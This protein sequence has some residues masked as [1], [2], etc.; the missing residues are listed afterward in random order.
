[1]TAPAPAPRWR[2]PTEKNGH[3]HVV[4][5]FV[6][7]MLSM[8]LAALNQTVLSTALPTI[9]GELNGVNEMLWVITAFILTS[10]I[11]MPVYGKLG[12]LMGRKSL[13][14]GAIVVFMAGSVLGA[15][16]DSMAVL[17]AARAVQGVGGGGL[18]ILS[19]A[20]I[21]DVVPARERGKYMG[22]MGGVFAIAS[23]AGPLLGGWFT[24]GPGWRWVFWINIPLGLLALAAAAVFLKLPRHPGRPRLDLG[25]MVLLAIATTCLVLF[26]TWGGSK[27]S[28]TDPVILVLVL[29]T[30]V[31]GAGFVAQERRTAE[32]IIPMHLFGEAN[33]NLTTLAGLFIGIAM[34]GAIGYLPTY[35]QMAFGVD[36]TASGLLMIPM[37]GTLLIASVVSGQLVSRTG[38]YKWMPIA[39]SL[40]VAAGLALLSTLTPQV[41]LWHVCAYIA[42]L[43]LGLGLSMQILVLIVQNTFPLRQVGTATASNNFFRQ[44]G[45]TLGSAVVGSVFAT[46]L[47]DLLTERLPAA[48]TRST[49]GGANSLTPAVVAGL[50][51]AFRNPIIASYNDALT[52]IFLWIMPL[53]LIATVLLCFVKEKPLATSVEHDIAA[54]ALAEGNLLITDDLETAELSTRTS[55]LPER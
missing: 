9:V 33:F 51:E 2:G 10:T 11:T 19:Q 49:P 52:P 8:L 27:Y 5:L 12:D 14:M 21:A 30:L 29:A 22:A 39:G 41:A 34:F 54:E 45:A 42:V 25:G 36:A 50:P 37:M 47:A 3:Q 24:E 13:L 26:S 40:T 1:M 32:P 55:A 44:I 23:V 43:G 15:L 48:A 53:A 28:W 18:M 6:G 20:A 4:L 17:I 16:A 7:L 46:R 31:A 38:R 35:L